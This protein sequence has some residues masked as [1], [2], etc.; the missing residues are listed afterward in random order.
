MEKLH[1]RH[2]SGPRGKKAPRLETRCPAVAPSQTPS[3]HI[4]NTALLPRRPTLRSLEAAAGLS[5]HAARFFFNLPCMPLPAQPCI[6]IILHAMYWTKIPGE[7]RRQLAGRRRGRNSQA[8]EPESDKP[9]ESRLNGADE[10]KPAEQANLSGK[11]TGAR[12]HRRAPFRIPVRK[13]SV[14]S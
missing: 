2:R 4:D 13:A 14:A 5:P 12:S 1:G 11:Q 3:R 9:L 6:P 10:A 8:K 7:I